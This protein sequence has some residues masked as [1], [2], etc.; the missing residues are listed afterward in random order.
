M[1]IRV[2]SWMCV[3]Y[4]YLYHRGRVRLSLTTRRNFGS[5]RI[6]GLKLPAETQED[7][8]SPAIHVPIVGWRCRRRQMVCQRSEFAIAGPDSR[9]VTV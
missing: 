1:R 4:T 2:L 8:F 3:R 7:F 9:I 6:A 5:W